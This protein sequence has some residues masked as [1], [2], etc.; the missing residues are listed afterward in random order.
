MKK[1][2]LTT[3]EMKFLLKMQGIEVKPSYCHSDYMYTSFTMPYPLKQKLERIQKKTGLTRSR[4]VQML[5]E[6]VDENNL[7][8]T[9]GKL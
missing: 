9:L 1:Y 3:Q 7:L 6:N 2:N 4:I 5:L 8:E